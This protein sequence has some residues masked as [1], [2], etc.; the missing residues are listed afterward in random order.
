MKTATQCIAILI[1]FLCACFVEPSSP[2]SSTDTTAPSN[3]TIGD[4][5][6]AHGSGAP[7]TGPETSS[8]TNPAAPDV[9]A[10][11][12]PLTSC[13]VFWC[14]N[15]VGCSLCCN[16]TSPDWDGTL[17]C[18][19]YGIQESPADGSGNCAGG[20]TKMWC[21]DNATGSRV[22][23]DTCTY[24]PGPKCPA[25]SHSESAHDCGEWCD[26]FVGDR[27][28]GGSCVNCGS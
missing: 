16:G 3:T 20:K 5:S 19:E 8:A 18:C 6:C 21:Q 25:G 27:C 2:P 9:E 17:E 1:A 4:T 24:P 22:Y 7:C 15:L 28:E 26:G 12:D 23:P 11:I 10:E 13:P 14:A